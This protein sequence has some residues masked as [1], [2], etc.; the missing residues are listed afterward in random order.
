M[1]ERFPY[2][3]P[4]LKH[5]IHLNDQFFLSNNFVSSWSLYFP[6]LRSWFPEK[7]GRNAVLRTVAGL[8]D[9][10]RVPLTHMLIPSQTIK[11]IFSSIMQGLIQ[12]CRRKEIYKVNPQN[13][14]DVFLEKIE[15]EENDPY[16]SFTGIHG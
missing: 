1:S 8:Q 6:F 11:K 9:F 4:K 13:L 5:Y 16:T 7:S 2:D 10:I 15:S 12:D 14:V 3:D